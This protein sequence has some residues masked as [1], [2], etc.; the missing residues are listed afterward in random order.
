MMFTLGFIL[1]PIAFFHSESS[2][3]CEL[4]MF[5]SSH[6]HIVRYDL[7]IFFVVNVIKLKAILKNKFMRK[8]R[9][10]RNNRSRIDACEN[11]THEIERELIIL[12]NYLMAIVGI[13]QCEHQNNEYMYIYCI[14]DAHCNDDCLE[15]SLVKTFNSQLS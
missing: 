14:S 11:D 9:N 6:L 3:I 4:F 13:C 10:V 1:L 2:L 7:Y 15:F 12:Y 8:W 5:T